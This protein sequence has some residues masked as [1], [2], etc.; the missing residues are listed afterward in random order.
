MHQEK[1]AA[2]K[3][4]VYMPNANF[5]AA[6][7]DHN[8]YIGL[9]D[10]LSAKKLWITLRRVALCYGRSKRLLAASRNEQILPKLVRLKYP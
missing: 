7:S 4:F 3:D 8:W 5:K 2:V 9:Q 1:K 6:W 10:R